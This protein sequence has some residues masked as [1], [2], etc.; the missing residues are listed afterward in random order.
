MALAREVLIGLEA[1]TT[2]TVAVA[3]TPEGDELARATVSHPVACSADGAAEQ[4]QGDAWQRV[5]AAVRQLATRVADLERRAMALA[6]T[7][8]GGGT[9]LVDEDGDPVLPAILPRR[10]SGRGDRLP[11]APRRD[12][13]RGRADHRLPDRPVVAERAA[14][15]A[16]REPSRGA[17]PCGERVLRQGL[18]LF[19]LHRRA[20]ERAHGR[21]RRVRQPHDRRL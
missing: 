8:P 19:L 12:R 15:L 16:G 4:E 14:R 7:G 1:G 5:A 17:R 18:A 10:P 11:L 6:L 2:M 13:A 9:W 3:F 20:R 21:A